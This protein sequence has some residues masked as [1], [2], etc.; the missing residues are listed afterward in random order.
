MKFY[1]VFP[2]KR[3]LKKLE[4]TDEIRLVEE[5]IKPLFALLDVFIGIGASIGIS[6][7][8]F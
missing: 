1:D 7:P 4:T 6:S 5:A 8:Y 2:P 3:L